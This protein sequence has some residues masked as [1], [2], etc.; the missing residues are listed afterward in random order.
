VRRQTFTLDKYLPQ[1]IM[2]NGE[3]ETVIINIKDYRR[4]FERLED[5][6]DIADLEKIR[7]GGLHV[8]KFSDFL[9]EN[10]NAL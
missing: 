7:K 8:R 9:T 2:K 3:P 5:K 6:D 10:D 4:L 1:V